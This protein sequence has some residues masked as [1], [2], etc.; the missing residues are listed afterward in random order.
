MNQRANE[1]GL[2]ECTKSVQY[3]HVL[4]EAMTEESPD[5]G[6]MRFASAKPLHSNVV[7]IPYM[8]HIHHMDTA[9]H[10]NMLANK[11]VSPCALCSGLCH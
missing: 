8:G 5:D 11:A 3:C 2:A 6:H 4:Q 7:P 10:V 1:W 9:M